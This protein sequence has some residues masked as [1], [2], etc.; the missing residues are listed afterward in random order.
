MDLLDRIII[1]ILYGII[2]FI[3]SAAYG[4][5]KAIS[6]AVKTNIIENNGKVYRV[7]P[8]NIVMKE[9]GND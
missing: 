2:I 8:A 7:V 3:F 4:Y 6:N 1:S 9:K 5:N